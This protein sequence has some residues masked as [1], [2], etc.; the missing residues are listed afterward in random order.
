MSERSRD[1]E[2]SP[3]LARE[4]RQLSERGQ[5]P[6]HDLW[7]GIRAEIGDSSAAPKLRTAWLLAAALLLGTIGVS[8]W[9]VT[10]SGPDAGSSLAF[11]R[12][13][14]DLPSASPAS[15]RNTFSRYLGERQQLLE[16]IERELDGYPVELRRDIR[17]N[18]AVIEAAM[19]EIEQSL[20]QLPAEPATEV[21]LAA[22][23]ERELRFLRGVSERL[24]ASSAN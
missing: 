16:R 22:L 15:L 10:R 20:S 11:A 23:Y 4:L 9:W 2:L 3:E 8:V 13:A 1:G 5:E 17:N 19:K 6:A 14:A 24:R 7:P 12:T 18:I 21:Q